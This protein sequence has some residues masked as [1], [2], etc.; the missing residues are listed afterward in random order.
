[1][2]EI[3][4]KSPMF[5][6]RG[7]RIVSTEEKAFQIRARDHNQTNSGELAREYPLAEAKSMKLVHGRVPEVDMP[8]VKWTATNRPRK[9]PEFL[10]LR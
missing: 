7:S 10:S 3:S 8:D 5:A 4:F 9:V 1:M 2:A 6:S